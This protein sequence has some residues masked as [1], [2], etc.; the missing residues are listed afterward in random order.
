MQQQTLMKYDQA[1]GQEKPYPSHAKQWRD[2][3]GAKTAWLFDPWTGQRR[4]ASDV[5]MD[6]TGIL[7]IPEGEE[8]F[9]SG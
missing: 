8:I 4:T 6:T 1:T 2:W 3:H 5:G 7:I 9:A